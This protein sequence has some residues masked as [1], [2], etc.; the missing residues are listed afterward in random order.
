MNAVTQQNAATAEQA[1]GNAEE[2]RF[3]SDRLCELAEQFALSERLTGASNAPRPTNRGGQ[4]E[5]QNKRAGARPARMR[6]TAS[7]VHE[8]AAELE[9]FIPFGNEGSDPMSHF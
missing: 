8:P 6:M 5:I 1:A 4:R 2:L 3:Q 9:R 7:Q